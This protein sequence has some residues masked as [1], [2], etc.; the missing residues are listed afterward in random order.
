MLA[1]R[2]PS[3]TSSLHI[4]EGNLFI[5]SQRGMITIRD[6]PAMEEFAHDAYGPPEE[7]YRRLMSGLFQAF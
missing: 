1:V 7:D 6:R 3:V 5:R 4:L 2:R